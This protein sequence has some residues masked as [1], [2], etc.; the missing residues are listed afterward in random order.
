[1]KIDL[2]KQDAAFIQQSLAS[3]VSTLQQAIREASTS[4]LAIYYAQTIN[5]IRLLQLKIEQAQ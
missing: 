1:M 2:S 5:T 3:T 4:E